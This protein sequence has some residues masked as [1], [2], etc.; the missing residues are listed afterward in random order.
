MLGHGPLT[1]RCV[2]ADRGG[3]GELARRPHVCE[4]Q[5]WCPVEDDR[6]I[7]GKSRSVPVNSSSN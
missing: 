2:L 6:R 7:L 4:I 3:E 5:S 1:G